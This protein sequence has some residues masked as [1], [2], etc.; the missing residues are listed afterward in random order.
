MFAVRF[1]RTGGDPMMPRKAKEICTKK[2]LIYCITETGTAV[3]GT[4]LLLSDGKL[5]IKSMKNRNPAALG[6]NGTQVIN[7]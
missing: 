7:S 2:F 1:P 5:I 4:L 3:I 6:M